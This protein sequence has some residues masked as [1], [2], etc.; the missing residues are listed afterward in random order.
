[1]FKMLQK[2]QSK[3]PNS[4]KGWAV[5]GGAILT[6]IATTVGVTIGGLATKA[7]TGGMLILAVLAFGWALSWAFLGLGLDI[8]NW[9]IMGKF[10][11]GM[12]MTNPANNTIIQIGWT[13]LRDLTNMFFILGLAYIGLA[14]ALNFASFNTKK[15]FTT[16][17]IIA[18]LI[19][20]TPVI[21]GLI[22]DSANIIM[23]FFL[24]EV[25]FNSIADS[26]KS[27][28]DA[29]GTIN[30]KN[31]WD[32][33][34]YWVTRYFLNSLYG[35]AAGSVMM[36][37]GLLL[38]L[39]NFIIWLLV[40]LSPIAFFLRIF[41]FSKQWFQK[42]WGWFVSWSFIGIPAA[43]FLY[44]SNHLM[45]LAKSN[46]IPNATQVDALGAALSP[47][48]ITIVFMIIAL[49]AT[50]KTR[51]IGSGIIMNTANKL[52]G[53][54]KSLPGLVQSKIGRPMGQKVGDV[55]GTTVTAGVATA[56]AG[57]KES[58][59]SGEGFFANLGAGA[60]NWA[61]QRGGL[62][63]KGMAEGLKLKE[64]SKYKTRKAAEQY[65][66]AKLGTADK[67]RRKELDTEVLMKDLKEMSEDDRKAAVVRINKKPTK[68]QEDIRNLMALMRIKAE[69]QETIE[70]A[71]IAATQEF[72]WIDKKVGKDLSSA[73]PDLADQLQYNKNDFDKEVEKRIRATNPAYASTSIPIPSA[74]KTIEEE[75][76]KRELTQKSIEKA[77]PEK[78]SKLFQLDALKG[79]TPDQL[80]EIARHI[81][82]TQLKAYGKKANTA[83]RLEF[84]KLFTPGSANETALVNIATNPATPP[85]VTIK[86]Q[87]FLKEIQSNPNFL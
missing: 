74:V 15:T 62:T 69:E 64:E 12:S 27:S 54:A 41:D 30:E 39:R 79:K 10:T 44:L 38:I 63:K 36:I 81:N 45:I 68:T 60:A 56:K 9:G 14:T 80:A 58:K 85:D 73:R 19:N 78:F 13:L 33:M 66:L 8:L 48:I 67:I 42:W 51:A 17:I 3:I 50:L 1:M 7:L 77:T 57:F 43:F 87:N 86:I 65:G 18:L 2:L 72:G 22:V 55:A 47:Y 24:S 21:C 23:N 61:R 53:K 76:F 52:A 49:I 82:P 16:L 46:Q 29:M 4:Q 40:I 84:G 71:D 31:A 59:A 28:H 25:N 37:F 6:G 35:I 75:R 5:L 32:N 26:Y 11:G 34:V 83:D 70:P 20:F